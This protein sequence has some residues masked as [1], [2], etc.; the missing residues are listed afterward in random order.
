MGF[1]TECN[2]WLIHCL[3]RTPA[4][5]I[6]HALYPVRNPIRTYVRLLVPWCEVSLGNGRRPPFLGEGRLLPRYR[7][8]MPWIIICLELS[9]LLFVYHLFINIYLLIDYYYRTPS[10]VSTAVPNTSVI[11]CASFFL[12]SG[13]QQACLNT[14]GMNQV[15]RC[16]DICRSSTIIWLFAAW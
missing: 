15:Q 12:I 1:L 7:P 8:L 2:A 10:S 4:F 11:I 3:V 16:T 9:G 13:W 14:G 5:C 6:N